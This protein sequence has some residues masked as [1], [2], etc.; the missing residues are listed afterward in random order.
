VDGFE[1]VKGN[2]LNWSI[3]CSQIK[4]CQ[5]LLT[6]EGAIWHY[7]QRAKVSVRLGMMVMSSALEVWSL[8]HARDYIARLHLKKKKTKETNLLLGGCHN[9]SHRTSSEGCREVKQTN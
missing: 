9:L 2:I 3:D 5:E 4:S 7:V 6:S 1:G 8:S